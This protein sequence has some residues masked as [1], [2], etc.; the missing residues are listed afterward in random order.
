MIVLSKTSR[1]ERL[2]KEAEAI[3]SEAGFDMLDAVWPECD[4][5]QA[6]LDV[7]RAGSESSNP[8]LKQ[9]AKEVEWAMMTLA[10][11]WNS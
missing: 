1:S 2:T 5:F 8:H 9:A 6:E 3:I 4:G 10:M 11:G 7:G